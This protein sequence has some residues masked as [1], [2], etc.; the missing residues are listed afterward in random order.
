MRMLGARRQVRP[1]GAAPVPHL[2]ICTSPLRCVLCR[3]LYQPA[4]M[5]MPV[6][7]SL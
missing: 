1:L 2:S 7:A 3:P 5:A 6:P 4:V